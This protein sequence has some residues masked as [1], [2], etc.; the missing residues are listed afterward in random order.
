VVN[1]LVIGISRKL[2]ALF[3]DGYR[4]YAEHIPQKLQP[5]AFYIQLL[6]AGI[7]QVVGNRYLKNHSFDII[8][9]PEPNGSEKQQ[10]Y[11]VQEKLLANLEYITITGPPDLQIRGSERNTEIV[12]GVLHFFIQ[13]NF[14]VN[15]PAVPEE[16]MSALNQ[17]AST[18]EG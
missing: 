14:Y 13:F 4:I 16:K 9:F 18:K 3:G 12:D 15:K 2:N 6:Q 7:E 8:F 17:R 5:P 11:E 1:D 10:C